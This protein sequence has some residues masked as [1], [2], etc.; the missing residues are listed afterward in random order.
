MDLRKVDLNLLVLF[1]A[2][3]SAGSVGKAAARLGLT[4]PA[5]SNGLARLRKQ[6]GDPLFSRR[7][8]GIVPTAGARGLITRV[9]EALS[10]LTAGLDSGKIDL[11]T[12]KRQFRVV[13]IDAL[14]PVIMP[15]II[16]LVAEHAPGVSLEIVA[17][18]APEAAA[19]EM[20]AGT[21]DLAVFLFPNDAPDIVT[22]PLGPT[23]MVTIARRG[24]P[25]IGGHLDVAKLKAL[26]HVGLTRSLRAITH[27]PK[28]LAA[29]S[30]ERRLVCGVDKIWS[31]PWMV[32]RSDLI[33]FTARRFAEAMARNHAIEIHEMPIPVSE[34][35]VYLMWHERSEADPGHRWLREA[36]I[37]AS[38]AWRARA[39]AGVTR[40][41]AGA[42]QPAA[43]RSTGAK[44]RRRGAGL[45]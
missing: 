3:Y 41:V 2:V 19:A 1:E 11:A 21:I 38:S 14:E 16:R 39:A 23:D 6:V 31:L 22:V 32:E 13:M 20:R 7:A 9:R 25:G 37:E 42:A 33:A 45:R 27:M 29:H 43:R 10:L 28:D 34:Q 15:P 40:P 36:M 12:Y 17:S 18:R 5:V 8:D 24:H 4:Q 26:P 30:V 35:Y 44:A